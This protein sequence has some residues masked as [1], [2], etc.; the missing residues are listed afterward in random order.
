M[1]PLHEPVQNMHIASA[2]HDLT[3]VRHSYIARVLCKP[4]YALAC[5][6]EQGKS[7]RRAC[8]K[9]SFISSLALTVIPT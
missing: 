2:S 9:S 5:H 7:N 8:S 6:R 3:L 1:L 4:S